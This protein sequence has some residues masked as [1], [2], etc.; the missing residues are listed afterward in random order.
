M[1]SLR[2]YQRATIDAVY[3]WFQANAEGHP[4]VVLP[5]GGGKSIIVASLIQ[6]ALQSWPE[7]RILMLTH[8][9]ELLEQNHEKMIDLWPDAPVG[10]FSA[11]SV[12]A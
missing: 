11:A 12:A 3:T 2:S 4:V 5:T 7:T 6:E 10:I 9:K 8:V 1:Y